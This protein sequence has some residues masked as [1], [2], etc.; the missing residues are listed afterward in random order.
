MLGTGHGFDRRGSLVWGP[1]SA[2]AISVR[3]RER[4]RRIRLPKPLLAWAAPLVDVLSIAGWLGV[5]LL[6]GESGLCLF[7]PDVR[8]HDAPSDPS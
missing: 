4:R 5:A 7:A 3:R 6:E 8:T 2:Q 1:S